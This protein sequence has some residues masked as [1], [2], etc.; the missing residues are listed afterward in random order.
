M[1][2]SEKL[3]KIFE[4][5]GKSYAELERITGISKSSLQRYANDVTDKIPVDVIRV[6]SEKMNVSATYL[7][8]WDDN[9]KNPYGNHQAN[10]AYFADKPELLALYKNIHDSQSLQLLFDSASDLSPE[11]LESVL[12]H[13]QG[14]RKARGLD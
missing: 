14:I 7:M 3:K 4:D 1:K 5:S 11:D 9:E 13:I 12:I 10:L 2:T 6:I 8:G